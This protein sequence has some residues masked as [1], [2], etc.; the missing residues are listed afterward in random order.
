[1]SGSNQAEAAAAGAISSPDYAFRLRQWLVVAQILLVAFGA[2]VLVPLLTGLA[3]NVALLTA[4]LGT[5]VF[6]ICTR[7]KV[8]VFLA[9]SFAFIATIIY[10]V[11]TWGLPA[12]LVILA[13]IALVATVLVTLLG[14]GWLR[15]LPILVGIAAGYAAALIMGLA[16]RSVAVRFDGQPAGANRAAPRTRRRGCQNAV[17]RA[18]GAVRSRG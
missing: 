17:R 11:Q 5:L 14:R 8:P 1:M 7:G 13:A 15:I 9:S 12:T 10:G 18:A 6:Q 4:G 2:L 16:G 3:P